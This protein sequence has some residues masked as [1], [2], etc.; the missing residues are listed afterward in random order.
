MRLAS[1]IR[2]FIIGIL[3][4]SVIGMD[5][6]RCMPPVIEWIKVFVDTSGNGT[7]EDNEEIQPD[8]QSSAYIIN[9]NYPFQIRIKTREALSDTDLQ[10][11]GIQIG[12]QDYILSKFEDS[13][14]T[15]KADFLQGLS[16]GTYTANIIIYSNGVPS[17]QSIILQIRKQ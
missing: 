9:A 10:N 12:E 8:P 7:F 3:L 2:F 13:E 5:G 4:I 6:C 17:I 14:S 1:I 16:P 11:S 15:Y